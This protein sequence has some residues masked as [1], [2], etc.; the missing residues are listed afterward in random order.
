MRY[1]FSFLGMSIN[2]SFFIVM[3]AILQKT[4]MNLNCHAVGV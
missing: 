2:V 1:G 4:C 3:Y